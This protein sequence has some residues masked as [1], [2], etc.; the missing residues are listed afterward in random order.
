MSDFTVET[1]AMRRVGSFNPAMLVHGT[2]RSSGIGRS[3]QTARPSR[4]SGWSGMYDK[5]KAAVVALETE[6]HLTN[7]EPLWTL[8]SSMF[9][10]DEGGWGGD[11]GPSGSRNEPPER[12][13]DHE[14][15][16]TTSPDQALLYRLKA[17]GIRCTAIGPWPHPPGSRRRSSTA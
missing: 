10:R 4:W 15:T 13:P 5:G 3:R 17:T 2:R 16:L 14:T 6:A 12:A 1:A 7:G 9:I 8:R 11:R